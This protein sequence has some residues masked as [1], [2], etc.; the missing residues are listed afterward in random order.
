[1]KPLSVLSRPWS[2]IGID[3]VVKLPVS[4]SF[5]STL[6]VVDHLTK[7]VHLVAANE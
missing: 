7:G 1:M 6:V 2:V 3:F 4:G 5:D